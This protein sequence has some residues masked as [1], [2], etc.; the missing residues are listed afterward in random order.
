MTAPLVVE[1]P[2]HKFDLNG[3]CEINFAKGL[4]LEQLNE[5]IY[6]RGAKFRLN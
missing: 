4:D 5:D 2:I 3:L 1:Q 6:P